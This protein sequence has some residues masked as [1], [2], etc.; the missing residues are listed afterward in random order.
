MNHFCSTVD[1]S[2]ERNSTMV[3]MQ[4]PVRRQFDTGICLR[5][6]LPKSLHCINQGKQQILDQRV[7]N[8]PV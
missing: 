6:G 5:Q 3:Y 8:R 7:S 4:S 2:R 1:V